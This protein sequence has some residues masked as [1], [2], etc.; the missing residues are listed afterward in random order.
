[1]KPLVY[2]ELLFTW[3]S[4]IA[5]CAE[6]FDYVIAGAGTCGLVLANRLSEDPNVR[7]AVIEAG[8]DVRNNPNVTEITAFGNALNT[9]IAWQYSTVPQVRA[10]NKSIAYYGGKAIGG[11]STINGEFLPSSNHKSSTEHPGQG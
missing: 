5:R 2:V 1:M 7:V 4:S 8:D 6:T 11:T 3:G 9:P 10:G